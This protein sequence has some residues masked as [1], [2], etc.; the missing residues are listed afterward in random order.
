[1]TPLEKAARQAL[2]AMGLIGADLVCGA[3]IHQKVAELHGDGDV[4]PVS[5][6][7]HAA[8]AALESTLAQQKAEPVAIPGAIPMTEVAARSRSMPERSEALERARERLDRAEP[9]VERA[10]MPAIG[11]Y[12]LATKYSD[13]DPGDAWALGFYAG[14]LDMGITRHDI[15]VAPRYLVND[16]S[17]ATIRENGYR[18]VARVRKDVGAWLLNVAAKQLEQS[19]PGT[20][21]IWT[22]LTDAAFDLSSEQQAE[23][24]VDEDM[25]RVK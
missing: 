15:K 9:V 16:S 14:E 22:M 23:P 24:V 21:N 18:R 12:V 6:R 10:V 19:P 11:D 3:S 2:D 1:M 13:G 17:G 4:C 7:W 25:G 8:F 20:V 5:L